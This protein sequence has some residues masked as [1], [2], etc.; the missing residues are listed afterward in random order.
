[1]RRQLIIL[2]CLLSSFLG[3]CAG[4]DPSA[5]PDATPFELY[6]HCGIYELKT[7]DGRIFERADGPLTDGSGN[8]PP[9]W[10][11][12]SQSGQLVV[13]DD[14]AVFTDELGHREEFRVREGATDFLQNCA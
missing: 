2:L 8:P 9:G 6:T 11:N 3:G 13:S 4:A 7:D 12:P 1:M 14:V 10:G 5:G